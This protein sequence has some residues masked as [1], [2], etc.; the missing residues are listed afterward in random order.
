MTEIKGEGS[1]RQLK[2]TGAGG[3]KPT[4]DQ[5]Y[6]KVENEESGFSWRSVG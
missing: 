6:I 1:N 3:F 5:R 4:P 2:M